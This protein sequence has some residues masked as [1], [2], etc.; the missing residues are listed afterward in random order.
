MNET[1]S[2]Q[3]DDRALPANLENERAILGGCLFDPEVLE[4]SMDS[5]TPAMFYSTGH[6]VLFAT[7]CD[8]ARRGVPVEIPTVW[9]EITRQGAE[10]HLSGMVYLA[11][12]VDV[13][14]GLGGLE[15]YVSQ[16]RGDA[17]L[18][19]MIKACGKA[20]AM[21]RAREDDPQ[22]IAGRVEQMILSVAEHRGADGVTPQEW[23]AG[24]VARLRS[25]LIGQP[26]HIGKLTRYSGGGMRN[27]EYTLVLAYRKTG[28]TRFLMSLARHK[29]SMGVPVLVFSFEM[30]KEQIG[31][32]LL[33]WELNISL[34][35]LCNDPFSVEDADVDAAAERIGSWPLYIEDDQ[36]M[37]VDA[38]KAM[39]RRYKKRHGVRIIGVD[40]ASK[41]RPDHV[42][43]SATESERLTAVAEQIKAMAR[44]LDLPVVML[45]QVTREGRI[46]ADGIPI[47]HARGS[48]VLENEAETV[49]ILNRPSINL[50]EGDKDYLRM[51][52]EWY[53]RA[54][55]H[56]TA[57]RNGVD[58]GGVEIIG[59]DE[60]T[61]RFYDNEEG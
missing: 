28:K 27:G 46:R 11:E 35:T 9:E 55:V 60:R 14:T 57:N 20:E 52:E 38:M 30:S 33:A 50:E 21:C 5:L 29:A 16:V 45:G 48:I 31:L 7:V 53:G 47:A 56:F 59:W 24:T 61:G 36:G 44:E 58:Q 13:R 41:V 12:A 49:M 54:Q 23:M 42:K 1:Y 39:A 8:M 6:Q 26:F 25:G 15:W 37:T 3:P 19:E 18:R 22:A 10:R 17:I 4:A 40:Y 43:P 32:M 2:H 34:E 51:K